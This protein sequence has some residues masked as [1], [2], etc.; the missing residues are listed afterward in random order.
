MSTE[1]IKNLKMFREST[2]ATLNNEQDLLKIKQINR[3]L[4]KL[5]CD[6]NA[7]HERGDAFLFRMYKFSTKVLNSS[8]VCMLEVKRVN[9]FFSP[10]VVIQ[11]K[12]V[13]LNDKRG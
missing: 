5:L 9:P 3:S 8:R 12:K 13:F 11:P 2:Q 4:I 1:L 6:T 7:N 10:R